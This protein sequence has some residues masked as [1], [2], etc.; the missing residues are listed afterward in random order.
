MQQKGYLTEFATP[1]HPVWDWSLLKE[2]I[3][4]LPQL[5]LSHIQRLTNQVGIIQHAKYT[6]PNYHHGYCLDDNARALILVTMAY[7]QQP[8]AALRES[9]NTYL[10]YMLYMQL[11]NGQFRNFL[12]FDNTFL[13]KVGSEDSYGRTIWALGFFLKI[14]PHSE[15]A[16][17]AQE[18]FLK[19]LPNCLQLRSN[20]AVAYCLLGLLH[21]YEKHSAIDPG[22]L[23][24][25]GVLSAFLQEEF[26]EASTADWQ[27]FEKI[28]AYDNAVM[29]LSL[30]RAATVLRNETA[31]KIGMA[32]ALFLDSLLFSSGHLSTVGNSNWYPYRE[33]K[34]KFGQQPIEI[35]SMLLLYKQIYL[36]TDDQHYKNRMIQ[37]FQWFFGGNDLGLH[38]Y[39]PGSKGCSDGLERYGINEN[40]GAESTI[41]FWKAFLYLCTSFD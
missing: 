4:A 6:I 1:N 21:Y 39:D 13:D 35:P 26:N 17:L 5:D 14:D 7:Q 30:L 10:A 24:H 40:Q 34:S 32:S 8:T 3:P 41:S 29:P 16:P 20:R 22:V 27:W 11:E 28:I 19:A 15:F 36:L 12:S 33:G 37:T 38:L 25:I 2:L 31:N 23:N 9:I 18:I